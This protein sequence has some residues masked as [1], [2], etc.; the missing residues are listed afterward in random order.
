TRYT[1]Y[2]VGQVM[3]QLERLGLWEKTYIFFTT[4]NGTSGGI[5]G[6][7]IGRM[8]QGGKAKLTENG[9]RQ[10]FLV[11]GPG[12]NPGSVTDALTDFSDLLPTFVELAGAEI[13]KDLV[14]DGHSLVDVLHGKDAE[15][16]REWMLAMGYGP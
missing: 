13:P 16:P 9:P 2:L 10:P 4:D 14:V 8:V 5:T 11:T 6:A 12:V 15:G 3:R 1:D 7:R